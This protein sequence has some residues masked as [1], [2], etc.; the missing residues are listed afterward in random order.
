MGLLTATH[1]AP[2]AKGPADFA[3]QLH[4]PAKAGQRCRIEVKGSYMDR[5]ETKQGEQEDEDLNSFLYDFNG[6]VTVLA[7][8]QGAGIK[9]VALEVERFTITEEDFT[10]EAFPKGTRLVGF[11]KGRDEVF[12][13]IL[14]GQKEGRPV[15]EGLEL[16]AL[17]QVNI[18]SR[19]DSANDD[20]V[21]GSQKRRKLGES[22]DFNKTASMADLEREG[23]RFDAKKFSGRTILDQLVKVDG[24]ECLLIRGEVDATDFQ[25]PL[26]KDFRVEQSSMQVRYS[27]KFPT[28]VRLPELEITMEFKLGFR[29]KAAPGKA[30]APIQIANQRIARRAIRII[31]L[32]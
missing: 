22:W 3:I 19:E 10:F 31:P 28:D 1:G 2:A 11:T 27:G 9:K 23:A 15:P 5:T 20:V 24:I 26:P 21:F 12:E 4:R 6:T 18:L 8:T 32:K 7:V 16:D 30:G 29:A 17:Q 14:D 13:V 25:P